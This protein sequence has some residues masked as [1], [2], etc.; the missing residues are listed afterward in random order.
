MPMKKSPS[1]IRSMNR[2]SLPESFVMNSRVWV[3]SSTP[4]TT[5]DEPSIRAYSLLLADFDFCLGF[6]LNGFLSSY[7]NF[8]AIFETSSR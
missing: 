6:L 4:F 1:S 3:F 8:F 2:V 5:S 7:L